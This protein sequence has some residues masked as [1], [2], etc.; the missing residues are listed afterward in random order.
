MRKKK[1]KGRVDRFKGGSKRRGEFNGERNNFIL[2]PV[3]GRWVMKTGR[4]GQ[5]IIKA[6]GVFP[7]LTS[8]NHATNMWD[9]WATASN[10]DRQ[11]VSKQYWD[12]RLNDPE[13]HVYP[14]YLKSYVP[15]LRKALKLL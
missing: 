1:L 14:I 6:K 4:I 8:Y 15:V 12:T 11:K 2:N 10:G 5:R 3:T 9:R 7:S 13:L